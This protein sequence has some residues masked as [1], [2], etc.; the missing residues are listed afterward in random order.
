V[1]IIVPTRLRRGATIGIV[2][3]GSPPSSPEKTDRGAAYLRDKGYHIV[4]GESVFA[5]DGYLAGSDE[6]RANDI[7][8]MFADLEIAAIFSLRGGYGS[9]RLL[10]LLDYK[11]VQRNPKIFVGYSDVT[12]LSMAFLKKTH[13]LTFA[14][15]MAA[16]EMNSGMDAFT[17]RAFWNMLSRPK[18]SMRLFQFRGDDVIAP[19]S[20]EGRLI[21]GNLAVLLS[22]IG[23]KYEP[24]WKGTI[25]F[26]ED[27]GENVYKIDRM[28]LQLRMGGVLGKIA[29]VLL[30]SFSSIPIET[31]NR[32]LIEVFKEYFQPL[33]I[34]V[35]WNVP[36]GHTMPKITLPMGA[37]LRIETTAGNVRVLYPVVR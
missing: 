13:L 12:A 36:F 24:D 7:N 19:G 32:D 20:C 33:R 17:E 5:H 10:D 21:G 25:L 35:V 11:I 30:G 15:P 29:G 26:L 9:A 23:T 27:V 34:P 4:F 22:L 8:R 37:Q 3:P 14:G 1:T 18:E 31:P 16:V 2:A 28:L 6:V